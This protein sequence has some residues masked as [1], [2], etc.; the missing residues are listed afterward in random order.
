MNHFVRNSLFSSF[1]F[2]L[3]LIPSAKAQLTVDAGAN[4]SICPRDSAQ[5]GGVVVA[6]GGLAPYH[7]SWSPATGLTS[8]TIPHPMAFPS[9]NTVYTLTVT[10]DTGAVNSDAV[11]VTIKNISRVDAGSDVL[12][13]K[14]AATVIGNSF[15]TASNGVSYLWSPAGTLDN[16]TVPRPT[17]APLVT[18]TYT[19][20]ATMAGC[21]P[22]T[23]YV[24]VTVRD[25]EVDA[26][27]D[28]TIDEGQSIT[29]QATGAF[30]YYW[31]ATPSLNNITTSNPDA[32]P[33]V[34][35]TYYVVG[36]DN[37][38]KC[39]RM[40][41]VTVHVV[42]GDKVFF[43]NTITPNGDDVND[44]WYVGNIYKYPDNTLQI[45]NR[46]GKLVYRKDGYDNSWDGSSFGQAL[47]AATYFYILELNN[48]NNDV[49]HGTITIIK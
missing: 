39:G 15:N 47:P 13:C 24:T 2:I 36:V 5:L 28:T 9:V 30:Y 6:S 41:S 43:Y 12:I 19:L 38:F 4:K 20:V 27:M 46:N 26:G 14:D 32:E 25:I 44:T 18:T 7:Y 49:Y 16:D 42:K 48:E 35:T 11:T 17:A 45:F 34:T 21:A 33:I 10:D 8:T 23:D 29:L 37:E 22:K 3:L 1:L 40:D 31:T